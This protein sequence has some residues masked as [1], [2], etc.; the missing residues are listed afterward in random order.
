MSAL[1]PKAAA[2]PVDV[3]LQPL[4]DRDNHDTPGLNS[5]AKRGAESC[6]ICHREYAEWKADS[7]SQSATNPRFLNLYRGTDITEKKASPRALISEGKAMPPDPALPDFGPGFK[8]DNGDRA[9]NC[10]TCHTP[11][12]AKIDTQNGCAWSGCHSTTNSRPRR[13]CKSRQP[14]HPRRGAHW[15]GR[16]R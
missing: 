7:H 3:T 8:L 2:Q 4:F 9:G 16:G 12:A 10:A 1:D 5:A 6:G 13:S 11:M 15:H 14:Y